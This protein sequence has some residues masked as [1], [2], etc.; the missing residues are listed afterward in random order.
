MTR[1]ARAPHRVGARRASGFAAFVA[2]SA[3]LHAMALAALLLWPD[4]RLF[5][6]PPV[7]EGLALVFTDV[8]TLAATAPAEGDPDLA[9]PAAPPA[10]PPVAPPS[11][12]APP[13]TPPPPAARP[14]PPPEPEPE[15]RV[16]EAPPPPPIVPAPQPEMAAVA[17]PPEAPDVVPPPDP[18]AAAAPVPEAPPDAAQQQAEADPLP[19]PPLPPQAA[20]PA[21]APPQRTALQQVPPRSPPAP[22]G[23][24]VNLGAGIGAMADARIGAEAI[25]AVVP[26][27]A[28]GGQRNEPPEYPPESR[29]RGEEGSVRVSLRV[30]PDGRVQMAEVIESSGHPALDRA[31]VAAVR[32]WRFRPATQAGLPVAATMQTAVHFRLTEERR[33]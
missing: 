3:V 17:P 1:P 8:A 29:R 24:G 30:G 10:P 5:E 15:S 21:E 7:G 27:T 4:G 22:R 28:E 14:A 18:I 31:A 33:R 19:T 2:G 26:P 32:R 16:A 25:G 13:A 11:A 9:V 23:A 6:E 12:I 20:P